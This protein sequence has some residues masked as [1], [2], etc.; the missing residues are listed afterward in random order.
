MSMSEERP[1]SDLRRTPY[2]LTLSALIV[3]WRLHALLNAVTSV[4]FGL[5]AG[6]APAMLWVACLTVGDAILQWQYARLEARATLVDSDRGLRRL[7]WIG[8]VKGVLWVSAPTAFAVVTRSPI[9]LAFVA[10]TAILLTALAVSTFRNSRLMF[11]S[12]ALVPI[13]ALAVCIVAVFG[14]STGAGGLLIGI[15]IVV[16]MLLRIATGTNRTVAA[17]NQASQ[18]AADAM[19]SMKTALARSEAVERRLRIA[20]EIADLYVFEADY[21]TRTFTGSGAEP[22]MFGDLYGGDDFWKDPFRSVHAEDL[23]SVEVAW[24]NYLAGE[25]PYRIEHRA[26]GPDGRLVWVSAFA[27]LVRDASGR[28]LALIGAL[29]NITDRKRSELALTKALEEAEAGSRV[30][31]EFLAV[32]SHEI[33]TPLN[34]V[35][36]IIQAMEGDE[37]AP[38]QRLRLEVARKSGETLLLLLNNVLDLSKLATGE[39]E[40][41]IGEIDIALVAD[42]ALGAVASTA[43]E[44]GL[45]LAL[46]VS[47]EASGV[48]AGDRERVEQLLYHLLSNAVKFTDAGSV[49]IAVERL[50]GALT[51]HVAD[52]GIGISA[53]QTPGLF[54]DFTQ[55]DASLT[56]R[57]GGSGLG[58]ALCRKVAAKMGGTLDV[59]SSLGCGSTFTARLPLPRLRDVGDGAPNALGPEGVAEQPPLR[60]LV[61]EDNLVNQ[62]VL[63]TLLQQIGIEP[64]IVGD[65]A[66][67]LTAWRDADWDVILM[68]VQMPVMDGVTA[69]LA[70]R[71]EEAASGQARTPIIAVTANVMAH[72]VQ[73]YR[74]AGIDEVVAKPVQVARLIGAIEGV[75]TAQQSSA[76]TASAAA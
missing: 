14:L 29:R 18:Q 47:Q 8:S 5:V 30:K 15:V 60:V 40:F 57:Y 56:R 70:I 68:D 67:A 64:V 22:E 13:A 28:P 48:Y 75:L 42:A 36:G 34:G 27:E 46:N 17:W 58:L 11:L 43:A 25:G 26:H 21:Q 31:G 35:L 54:A 12:V 72:Q 41:E 59:Q 74:T 73:A 10:V 4:A 23:T 3:P 24:A 38:A 69:A 52:T 33:R 50:D 2:Q 66:Q 39:L 44:K 76:P 65:G 55:I 6:P 71:N 7:A 16:L 63:R 1:A 37:L 61:A 53:E 51:I 62:L 9:G 19:A 20:V 32:M 45:S 49:S